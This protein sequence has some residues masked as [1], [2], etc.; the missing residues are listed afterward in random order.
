MR[1]LFFAMV[2]FIGC[3]AVCF[4][5]T[6]FIATLQHEGEFTHYY[7]AGALSSAYSAAVDG[8]IIT[9]S[10]ATFTSPG[11]IDKGITLRGAGVEAIEKTYISGNVRF[12]STDSTRVTTVEGIKF[13][14]RTYVYNNAS[15]KS[16]GQ[17]TGQGTIKFIKKHILW[18]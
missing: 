8:D 5:Q 6:S 1:K 15:G 7:G 3:V 4:A 2:A 17:S 9:L 12:H 14:G 11:T 13:S 18:F 16:Q 10:P